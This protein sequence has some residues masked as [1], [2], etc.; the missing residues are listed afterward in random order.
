MTW[1]K[2]SP[3]E[4]LLGLIVKMFSHLIPYDNTFTYIVAFLE[5]QL[6]YLTTPLFSILQM[7][8]HLPMAD[9][10]EIDSWASGLLKKR[11]IGWLYFR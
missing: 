8:S 4:S 9:M 11:N 2:T 6:E 10:K 7:C 5:I 1:S 3:N